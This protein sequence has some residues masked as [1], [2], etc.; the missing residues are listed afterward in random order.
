MTI[1]LKKLFILVN[2]IF[3]TFWN[4]SYSQTNTNSD[5]SRKSLLIVS[6]VVFGVTYLGTIIGDQ[7]IDSSVNF[8]ELFVPVIG[9]F[10]A[11]GNYDNKVNPYYSGRTRDKALFVLSGTV[12]TIS[13]LVFFFNLTGNK[14]SQLSINS[15]TFISNLSINSDSRGSLV[16]TYRWQF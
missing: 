4:I 6:G 3:F 7:T 5:K 16:A 2:L 8:P 15:N 9:P 10:L 14:S 1:T 11:L 13:A 12:Q